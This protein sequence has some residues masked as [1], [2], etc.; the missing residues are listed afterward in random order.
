MPGLRLEAD[1]VLACDE[2]MS[3]YE[4]GVVDI[5][6]DGRIAWVGRSSDAPAATAV[7]RVS[8]LLMPGLVNAHCHSPMTLLRG[9]GEGLPLDRWLAEVIWPREGRLEPDDVYWGMT[10]ASA[11]LLRYGV[12]TTCEMYFHSAEVARAVS[13]SGGRVV[14]TPALVDAPWDW[15]GDWRRQ[16]DVMGDFYASHAARDGRVTVGIG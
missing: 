15:L 7:E 3:W 1:A 6:A 16:L 8:G 9:Q 13:D 11:E 2:A 4:P 5:A 14:V 10:L 12:T